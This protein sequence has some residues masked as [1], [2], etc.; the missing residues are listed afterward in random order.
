MLPAFLLGGN[1]V[2]RINIL[3]V[4]FMAIHNSF[5]NKEFHNTHADTHK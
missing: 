5:H 1:G 3:N 4:Y 2:H